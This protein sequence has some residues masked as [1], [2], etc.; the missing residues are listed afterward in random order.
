MEPSK[1]PFLGFCLVVCNSI[2]YFFR[3]F[4][5]IAIPNDLLEAKALG[6]TFVKPLSIMVASKNDFWVNRKNEVFDHLMTHQ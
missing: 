1:Y 5:I 6:F 3:I 2:F 4:F